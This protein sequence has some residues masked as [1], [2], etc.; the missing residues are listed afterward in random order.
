MSQLPNTAWKDRMD[1]AQPGF[2]AAMNK[3][4]PPGVC[5]QTK[6]QEGTL[7]VA[8]APVNFVGNAGK[9]TFAGSAAELVTDNDSTFIYVDNAG[10]L[11]KVTTAD[12]PAP[13]IA[14]VYYC[15]EIVAVAGVITEI[16]NY[17][18]PAGI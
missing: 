10:A 15:A 17:C 11:Q 12:F 13:A 1:N 16:H 5:F 2:V 6:A 4:G 7:N 9:A 14:H 18:H 3:L 8:V